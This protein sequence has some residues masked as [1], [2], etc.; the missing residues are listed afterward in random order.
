MAH[1][2][3]CGSVLSEKDGVGICPFCGSTFN[4]DSLEEDAKLF[5]DEPDVLEEPEEVMDAD[6]DYEVPV[7]DVIF[8]CPKCS[9]SLSGTPSNCPS[10]GTK[11]KYVA[12]EDIEAEIEEPTEEET[13]VETKEEVEVE[14]VLEE[15]WPE[16]EVAYADMETLKNNKISSIS[17]TIEDG[18]QFYKVEY[19]D[20]S[21]L[22][23]SAKAMKLRGLMI[24]K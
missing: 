8:T 10:C 14:P 4:L 19:R 21:V 15:P 24:N 5:K 11:L 9:S 6:L 3:K 12:I 22:T 20:G 7:Y 13:P 2:K 23:L 17:R 18:E 16:D 1:C